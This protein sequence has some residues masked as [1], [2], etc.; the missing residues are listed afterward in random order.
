MT[1]QNPTE[2]F[3]DF[4]FIYTSYL[5]FFC[6]DFPHLNQVIFPLPVISTFSGR[7]SVNPPEKPWG[8]LRSYS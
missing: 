1:S 6:L 5:H 7:G 4:V 3:N 2:T 8:V